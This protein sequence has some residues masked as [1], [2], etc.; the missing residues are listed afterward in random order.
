MATSN[1]RK[2]SLGNIEIQ[3]G[4]GT[5]NHVALK[6]TIYMDV[7]TAILYKNTDGVTAWNSNFGGVKEAFYVATY[8]VFQGNRGSLEIS[9]NG[10]DSLNWSIPSDFTSLISIE[11]CGTPETTKATADVDLAT[12]YSKG[13]ESET[14]HS[15]T[16]TTITFNFVAGQLDYFDFSSVVSTPE[17]GD[18]GGLNWNQN[19]AG[20]FNAYG[21]LVKFNT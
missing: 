20:I 3:C 21:I 7:D 10:N 6:G 19:N 2:I 18:H 12:D 5:P 8:N 17:A 9:S 16:D 13:G 14:I 11:V 15:E 4:N 1:L